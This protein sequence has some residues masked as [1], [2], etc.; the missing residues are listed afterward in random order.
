MLKTT[1][2]PDK[3]GSNRNDGSRSASSRNDKSRPASRKNDGDGEVNGFSVG[4]NGVEHAKKSEKL[5]KSQKLSKSEKL[6]SE[7]TSQFQNSAK[8]RKKSS[9]NENFT[10]FNATEIR[11][12]FLTSDAKI[13]FN[14]LQLA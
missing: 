10:N 13:A 11:P 14:R 9:K 4:R 2:S 3:P 8:L 5:Y 6:K 7:K 1:R 12:K